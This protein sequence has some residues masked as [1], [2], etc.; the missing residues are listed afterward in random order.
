M[1]CILAGNYPEAAQWARGQSLDKDE[2]F[3]PIEPEE[4][5]SRVNFHVLVVGTAGLNV[6]DS[7]W[8]YLYNLAKERGRME[9]K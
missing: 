1:I 2:W 7:Y 9:R 5:L 3:Y 8:N 4:L 6:P